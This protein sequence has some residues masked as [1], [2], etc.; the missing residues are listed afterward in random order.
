MAT[1]TETIR[2]IKAIA[3]DPRCDPATRAVARQKF[4]ELLKNQHLRHPF[5]YYSNP[6]NLTLRKLAKERKLERG[7]SAI[8][9]ISTAENCYPR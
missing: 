8:I 6:A 3:D 9:S 5:G 4:E 1:S 2:R 7:Q